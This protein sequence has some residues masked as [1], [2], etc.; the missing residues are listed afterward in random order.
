MDIQTPPQTSNLERWA[1]ERIPD[2]RP[3]WDQNTTV[4]LQSIQHMRQTRFSVSAGPLYV[5][6]KGNPIGLLHWGPDQEDT[7]Q[8]L[9]RH[10]DEALALALPDVPLHLS[11]KG[12]VGLG[13]LTTTGAMELASSLPVQEIRPHGLKLAPMPLG[14]A[15][16]CPL[17]T[18]SR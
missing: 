1:D 5:A 15:S 4:G 8:K 18:R 12:G 14:T 13:V 11:K 2:T 6:L 3:D 10:L 16:G 9:K 17:N 7:F